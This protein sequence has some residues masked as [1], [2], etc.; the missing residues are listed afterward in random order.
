[1]P[2][3]V[4]PGLPAPRG[5]LSAAAFDTLRGSPGE[6]IDA[7]AVAQADPY[8]DDL[9]LALYCCYEL[10]YRG[11]SG[12][13]ADLEWDPQLLGPRRHLERAFLAT[14]RADVPG[15]TD[16]S[17]EIDALLVETP[18]ASGV[19]HYLRRCGQLWQ[20][21]EYVAHRSLYHLKE[22]DPQAWVIPRLSGPAKTALVTVEHDEYGAG[23]P[24]RMHSRLF[25]DMM[26]ELG[27][28]PQ[29][30]AYL[31]AAPAAT[32]TEV[33]FM[34]LCGLH[35]ALRGALIGQF[36]TVELT[37]SPG[38]DRLVRAMRR[39]GCGPAAIEFYAEHV[40]ADAA[41]EQLVRHG[42]ITPLLAS[43]PELATDV[44]FGIQAAT[45]LADRFSDLLLRNWTAS[46]PTLRNPLPDAPSQVATRQKIA[47]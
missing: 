22:A 23:N 19:S 28:C 25:G 42:V 30:G 32:L 37:S 34:S 17:A 14:L 33:N 44:V 43:E 45:L 47:P 16:V 18:D 7:A 1:M 3:V 31:D 5:P 36:A 27:L 4:A 41:H 24:R 9:Q 46:Q 8:G 6:Q 39:L 26:S 38:S 15:G 11:F 35:R 2:A 12:V 21:R 20:L 10:H 29:Y 13:G 40:E